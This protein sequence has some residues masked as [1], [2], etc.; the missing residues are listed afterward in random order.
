MFGC[1]DAVTKKPLK[2]NLELKNIDTGQLVSFMQSDS[3]SGQY[4][5][6]LTEGAEYALF[7]TKK[8]YLYQSRPFNYKKD[9]NEALVIDFELFPAQSGQKEGKRYLISIAFFCS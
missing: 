4:L 3:I 8:G 9:L 1:F 7:V 6:V 5:T 2:A